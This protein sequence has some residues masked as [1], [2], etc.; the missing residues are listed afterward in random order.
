[1]APGHANAESLLASE[2]TAMENQFIEMRSQAMGKLK[3]DLVEEIN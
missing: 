3:Q 2:E 1:M